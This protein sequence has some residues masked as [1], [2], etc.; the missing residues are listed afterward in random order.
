MTATRTPGVPSDARIAGLVSTMAWDTDSLEYAYPT[1]SSQYGSGYYKSVALP[2]FSELTEAQK[3]A[4]ARALDVDSF[5][6]PNAAE[7]F[8]VEGFTDLDISTGS[9]WTAE[10]RFANTS[11][12]V[13]ST[14][15]AYYPSGNSV[16]GDAWFGGKGRDPKIG[17][18]DYKTILHE[19]GHALGLKHSHEE[20]AG[21]P[22]V[23]EKW[24]GFE[25]TLMSY[26][27]EIGGA[28]SNR[29]EA[30]GAPQTFMMLDIAALQYLYGANFTTS[31]DDTVYKWKPGSGETRANGRVA[32]DPD[33]NRIFATIWDGGGKD[34]YD[35]SKYQ[36]GVKVNLNPGKCSLFS[37]E[38]AA[39]LDWSDG[40][41]ASGNIY[42]ALLYKGDKRSL[43]ECAVGGDGNDK[44]IGNVKANVLEGNAGKDKLEGWKGKDKL[45]GG[46]GKDRLHGG[47]GADTLGGGSGDDV[48]IFKKTSDTS[49]RS[50]DT[51]IAS[52]GA[53]AFDGAGRA[54]GD[55]I[56]LSAIDAD[57]TAR[58]NQDFEFR[59]FRKHRLD[60]PGYLWAK[61]KDNKTFIRGTVDTD[62]GW[63]FEIVIKD[64]KKVDASDY[65]E[66]DFIL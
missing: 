63:D 30:M 39:I 32:L 29:S 27:S 34:T 21:R 13:T 23:P 1:S 48:F 11:S 3:N 55:R 53:K 62:K 52:G 2:S 47:K 22:E 44:L 14:A 24:D 64:G 31:A 18:S 33:E 51:I 46:D 5:R 42:N 54:G 38:Q 28:E 35:L 36:T 19:I 57:E 4:V 16:G 7:G 9:A 41:R 56:D 49:G 8:T 58:G 43:I 10:L 20:K 66:V 37:E 26:R 6:T 65:A 60:D 45:L 12:S 15:S 61:E 25:Y 50:A 17:N 40:D 59:D